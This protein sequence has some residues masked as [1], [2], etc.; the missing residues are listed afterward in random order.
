M[1][2]GNSARGVKFLQHHPESRPASN[3]TQNLMFSMNTCVTELTQ[4]YTAALEI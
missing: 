3:E 1:V 2:T 4:S